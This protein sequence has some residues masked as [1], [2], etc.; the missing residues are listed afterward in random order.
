MSTTC[1]CQVNPDSLKGSYVFKKSAGGGFAG[2]PNGECMATPPDCRI[3]STLFIWQDLRVAKTSDTL[4]YTSIKG[5]R[6]YGSCDTLYIGKASIKGD[7]LLV[8]YTDKPICSNL[9]YDKGLGKKKRYEKLKQPVI[10]TFVI[11]HK[12]GKIKGLMKREDEQENY[13]KEGVRNDE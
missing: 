8:T 13:D 10:Q 12:N 2:G 9:F 7:T 3:T 6:I 4:W 5:I 1:W 11:M